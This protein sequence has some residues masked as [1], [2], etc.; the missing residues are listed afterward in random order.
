MKK[1]ISLIL[2]IIWMIFIFVMS[3][4]DGGKSANQS[5]FL[6]NIISNIFNITNLDMLSV[7]IR[8]LAHFTEYFILGMLSYNLIM[9]YHKEWYLAIIICFIYAI[10]DE[11]HQIY[12]PL[13]S[14]QIGDVLIDLFGAI[15]GVF[16]IKKIFDYKVVRE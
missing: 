11:I 6:V 10:S 16:L 5:N 3:S 1:K 9:N 15:L 7:I 12:V 14:A 8:K 13:R 4:F 2:V